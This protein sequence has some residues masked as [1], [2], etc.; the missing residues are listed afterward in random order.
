MPKR[1]GQSGVVSFAE[2]ESIFREGDRGDCMYLVV[3][4]TVRLSKSIGG[5][6]QEIGILEK[7][8]FFGEMAL[9]EGGQRTT[10][11]RAETDV[12]LLRIDS[13]G[14]VNLLQLDPEIP[15][16]MLR[17]LAAALRRAESR[18]DRVLKRLSEQDR[19]V[20]LPDPADA[21]PGRVLVRVAL[22]GG[23]RVWELRKGEALIGRRD[24]VAQASPDIDLDEADPE[25][26]VSRV[27]ARLVVQDGRAWMSE[28]I[29]VKNGTFVNGERL[30]PGSPHPLRPGDL[31][32]CGDV[33]L[34]C[35][36]VSP[37]AG[38]EGK[39]GQSRLTE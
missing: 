25:H 12:R 20:V 3:A 28:E 9:I 34:R 15:L 11:V 6:E 30:W 39:L 10:S 19:Q 32:R 1:D 38:V 14:F 26:T 2:G 27:H 37:D 16:R 4:G 5:I 31:V 21:A 8:D 29:A 23:G 35:V 22:E 36:E 7:G 13:G 24:N 17:G 18:L 33:R